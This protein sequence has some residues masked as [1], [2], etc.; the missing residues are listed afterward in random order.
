MFCGDTFRGAI[1]ALLPLRMV[2][3][4]VQPRSSSCLMMCEA[5]KPPP[6][7]THAVYPAT[8]GPAE[9]ALQAGDEAISREGRNVCAAAEV[10]CRRAAR[11]QTNAFSL[12]T[13]EDAGQHATRSNAGKSQ[14]RTTHVG[15]AGGD[16]QNTN[17][18]W[19]VKRKSPV[20]KKKK[21]KIW[22]WYTASANP[23]FF[24]RL[25][26]RVCFA[27]PFGSQFARTRNIA[28]FS[29]SF[30]LRVAVL[31]PLCLARRSRG[32]L[33]VVQRM[34]SSSLQHA[35]PPP[36]Q[37]ASFV[38]SVN[39]YLNAGLLNRHARAAELASKAA[40]KSMA[41]FG[42]DSLMVAR[43]K[44][45]ESMALAGLAMAANSATEQQ[46]TFLRTFRALLAVI[47][48]L[49]RRLAADTLLPGSLRKEEVDCYAQYVAATYAAKKVPVPTPT[50]LQAVGC[51]IGYDVLLDALHRSLDYSKTMFQTLWPSAGRKTVESFVRAFLSSS[52]V[53]TWR[54]HLFPGTPSPGRHPSH[55]R[56][57]RA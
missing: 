7:V 33:L 38:S 28:L 42:D 10:R 57:T 31:V 5:T 18:I 40:D 9:G 13:D 47:A 11:R 49:Q 51:L 20:G 37:L 21:K 45:Q 3:R 39:K 48:I 56:F 1:R 30:R 8:S 26:V 27:R 19:G 29:L 6:P 22:F 23:S 54:G 12:A 36:D 46:A 50:E 24:Q 16:F 53:L 44:L 25:S 35:P 17:V 34:A 4:T 14:I 52:F 32:V 2:A 41:L 43:L 55:S 15:G